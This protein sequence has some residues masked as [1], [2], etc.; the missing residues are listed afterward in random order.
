MFNTD[1]RL[2]VSEKTCLITHTSLTASQLNLIQN[3][4]EQDSEVNKSDQEQ[5]LNYKQKLEQY[6]LTTQSRQK[7]R[8]LNKNITLASGGSLDLRR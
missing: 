6:L 5:V 1:E 4:A 8:K 7:H 3:E 2:L